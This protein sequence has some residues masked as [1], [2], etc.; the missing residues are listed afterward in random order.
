[1]NIS[2]L[3]G[4]V[5]AWT[6]LLASVLLDGGGAKA[7]LAF[8]KLSPAILVFGGTFG[9]VIIGMSLEEIKAI[10]S[11]FAVVFKSH[12]LDMNGTIARLCE[13]AV[14]SRRDGILAL[15]D[16]IEK[17]TDPFMK[18]GFQM[19]VDGVDTEKLTEVMETEFT[20]LKQWYKDGE[21]FFKQLGGFSPTLGIIGT[22]LGLIHMLANL[23]NAESMG[24]AIAMAFIAT[25]YGVSFANLVYLP[26]GNKVKSVSSRELLLK[27]IIIQALVGIQSGVSPRLLEQS[28]QCYLHEHERSES[29][30]EKN[31]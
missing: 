19:C 23:E 9:A 30:R 12:A 4:L 21:E 29:P 7:L 3:I 28:L 6:C 26:L 1:M 2:T 31:A 16:D 17:L 10:P 20:T 15:E 8:V 14:R 27:R 25:M 24:P 11:R 18:K 13:M 22:V 5:M